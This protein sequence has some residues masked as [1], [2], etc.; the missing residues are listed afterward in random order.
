MLSTG[1]EGR[2]A[3]VTVQLVRLPVSA[4]SG[5]WSTSLGGWR[6]RLPTT[7]ESEAVWDRQSRHV[8]CYRRPCRAHAADSRP[9]STGSHS[10]LPD[11]EPALSRA[12]SAGPRSHCT[13]LGHT[14]NRNSSTVQVTVHLYNITWASA[15]KRWWWLGEEMHGVWSRGPQTKR[16]T[17]EDWVE[18]VEKECQE[19]TSNKEDAIDHSRWRK[20]IKDV[21]W[22]GWV[23]VGECF[24]WY[25]PTQ[26]VPD[27][28]PLNSCVCV[29]YIRHR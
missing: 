7:V 12:M 4:R 18:V 24:F 16:K 21:R 15:A 28:G 23:W 11:T 10:L 25:R 27:K 9:V 13:R 14:C 3:P 22:S 1:G 2:D 19:R 6:C 20:L 29:I 17:K 5:H 26:A 8:R